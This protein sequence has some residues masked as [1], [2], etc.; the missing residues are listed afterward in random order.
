[1]SH[2][3]SS[4]TAFSGHLS[5]F[6]EPSEETFNLTKNPTHQTTTSLPFISTSIAII[7]P[8]LPPE[9]LFLQLSL[10]L[11]ETVQMLVILLALNKLINIT[12]T[13]I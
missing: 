6:L 9:E 3:T 5:C 10:L 8:Y 11:K 4:I 13:N 2:T 1:M 7:E 12:F